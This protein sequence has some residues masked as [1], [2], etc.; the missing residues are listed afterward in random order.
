M[1]L[2]AWEV[3]IFFIRA[4]DLAHM[5]GAPSSIVLSLSLLV[6]MKIFIVGAT[7]LLFFFFLQQLLLQG[8]RAATYTVFFLLLVFP[9]NIL[10]TGFLLLSG[11]TWIPVLGTL[12]GFLHSPFDYAAIGLFQI[13]VLGAFLICF[14]APRFSATCWRMAF[15]FPIALLYLL[16]GLGFTPTLFLKLLFFS[17]CLLLLF[18]LYAIRQQAQEEGR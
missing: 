3:F 12:D 13:L 15:L 5:P 16:F 18:C 2:D 17:I 14:F 8:W 11:S 7:V 9:F 10:R 6:A 4:A 1:L